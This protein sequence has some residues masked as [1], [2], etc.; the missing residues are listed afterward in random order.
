MGTLKE[1]FI[2]AISLHYKI[3]QYILEPF[4]FTFDRSTCTI[5]SRKY[6][7]STGFYYRFNLFVHLFYV[8]LESYILAKAPGGMGNNAI[9][10]VIVLLNFNVLWIRWEMEP[11][12]VPV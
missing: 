4:P 7:T 12:N 2:P 11:D 8:L 1:A 6:T 9:A 3:L 5:Q 10:F